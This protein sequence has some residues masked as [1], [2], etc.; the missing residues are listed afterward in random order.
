MGKEIIQ[1]PICELVWCYLQSLLTKKYGKHIGLYRND[2]LAAFNEKPQKI[3]KN[4][5]GYLQDFCVSPGQV[6]WS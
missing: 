2:G 6:R 3:E 5:K 1:Q 4:Q